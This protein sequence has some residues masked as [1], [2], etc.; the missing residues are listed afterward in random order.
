[1]KRVDIE[2]IEDKI[3]NIMDMRNLFMGQEKSTTFQ[4]KEME[5][6]NKLLKEKLL[7][8]EEKIRQ[9]EFKKDI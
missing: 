2:R 7:Q 4:Q 8:A 6:E 3:K 9:L 1:L 5:Y